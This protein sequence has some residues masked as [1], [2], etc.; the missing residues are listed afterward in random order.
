MPWS[1]RKEVPL[2]LST[3]CVERDLVFF[4]PY[5]GTI[6]QVSDWLGLT[7][8]ERPVGYVSSVLIGALTCDLNKVI[9]S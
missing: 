4:K 1:K 5:C 7:A 8:N 3:L 9:I 2:M 6:L